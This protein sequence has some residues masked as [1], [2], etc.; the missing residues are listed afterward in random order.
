MTDYIKREE[1]K[2]EII[3]W[4]SIEKNLIEE[5]KNRRDFWLSKASKYAEIKDEMNTDICD[6]KAMELEVVMKVIQEQPKADEWIPCSERMPE[7]LE[8]VNIT[9]TNHRP[10]DYYAH[11]KDVHFTDTGVLYKGKWFWWS[12]RAE[13]TL[14]EYGI[15]ELDEIADGI[16]VLAWQPLPEPWKGEADE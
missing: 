2:K 8:P 14:A 9:W 3:E 11:I 4:A 15:N 12:V 7:D 1:V 16:E 5:I 6:G 10:S 13:D